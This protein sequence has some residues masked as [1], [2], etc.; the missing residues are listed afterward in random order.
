MGITQL[1][2]IF[3]LRNFERRGYDPPRAVVPEEAKVNKK[4]ATFM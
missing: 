1:P 4:E 3:L 2:K